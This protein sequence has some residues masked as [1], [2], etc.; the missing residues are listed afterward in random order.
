[1]STKFFKVKLFFDVPMDE[2]PEGIPPEWIAEMNPY[3]GE[4]VESPYTIMS[5]AEVNLH[6]QDF[7]D[8][9]DAWSNGLVKIEDVLASKID[10]AV[11]EGTRIV[12][13]VRNKVGAR[14]LLLGKTEAQI[15]VVIS[16]LSPAKAALE[17]GALK[18]GRTLISELKTKYPE[19]T[20]ELDWTIAEIT[21]FTGV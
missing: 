7:Q 4:E 2:R 16:D 21:K 8:E 20:T 3:L 1:M 12:R 13:E 10:A 9:Y 15:L 19:Y 6:K 18:T 5:E 14:N 11:V 17:G